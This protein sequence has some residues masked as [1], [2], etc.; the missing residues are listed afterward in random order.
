MTSPEPGRIKLSVAALELGCH[1]ETLRERVRAGLL[2]VERGP[3]G[4]YYVTAEALGRMPPIERSS[5]PRRLTPEEVDASWEAAERLVGMSSRTR[6]AELTL[7]RSLRADPSRSRRLYRLI[8]VQALDGAGLTF[9]EIALELGITARHVGRL[10]ARTVSIA[11]RKEIYKQTDRTKQVTKAAARREVDDIRHR[12]T[13]AGVVFHKR[14]EKARRRDPFPIDTP[15]SPRQAFVFKELMAAEKSRLR[16]NGLTDDQIQ[17]IE[18]VGIGTDELN[19]LLLY[20]L[21]SRP[22]DA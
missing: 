16:A 5:P 10:A 4:A 8:T 7:L 19:F 15:E 20:G 12:L 21:P 9:A 2:D 3:H 22:E 1:V 11:L 14:S 17:A 18:L 13:D 6:E